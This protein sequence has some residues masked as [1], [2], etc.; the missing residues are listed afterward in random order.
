MGLLLQL[1]VHLVTAV[2]EG[3]PQANKFNFLHAL[4]ISKNA[5]SHLKKAQNFHLK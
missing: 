1:C 3:S 5:F 2:A 4:I